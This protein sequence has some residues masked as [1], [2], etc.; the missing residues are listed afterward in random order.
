MALATALFD[1]AVARA[2]DGDV[3]EALGRFDEAELHASAV[4][5]MAGGAP[6]YRDQRLGMRAGRAGALAKAGRHD[7]AFEAALACCELGRSI[8]HRVAAAQV[9]FLL[10][11]LDAQL[12]ADE[13]AQRAASYAII[14]ASVLR[15]AVAAGRLTLEELR[16]DDDLERL[17][18]EPAFRELL[19][20]R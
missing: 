6:V 1:S 11:E 12:P 5:E 4:D 3:D 20:E 8:D 13:A 16:S 18:R 7:E 19:A 14:L 17:R 2:Q 9:A 15:D 10:S